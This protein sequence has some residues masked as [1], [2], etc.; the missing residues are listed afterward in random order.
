MTAPGAPRGDQRYHLQ[1]AKATD[2][3]TSPGLPLANYQRARGSWQGSGIDAVDI[4]RFSLG[5]RQPAGVNLR[6]NGFKLQLLRDTG[7]RSPRA[8][9][10]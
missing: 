2:D 4:Y 6:G 1:V 5:R 9:T 10:G 8:T 3:D 7:H